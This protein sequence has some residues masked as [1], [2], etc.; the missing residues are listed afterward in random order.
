MTNDSNRLPSKHP[1]FE[2]SFRSSPAPGEGIILPP[3]G[4]ILNGL[5]ALPSTNIFELRVYVNMPN[6]SLH[7]HCYIIRKKRIALGQMGNENTRVFLRRR[8]VLIAQ[9][10]KDSKISLLGRCLFVDHLQPVIACKYKT[11]IWQ[12]APMGFILLVR[13]LDDFAFHFPHKKL[14]ILHI[15]SRQSRLCFIVSLRQG[16][17][18]L[19]LIQQVCPLVA[20]WF[21]VFWRLDPKNQQ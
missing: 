2:S 7:L 19:P 8:S 11:T 3:A 5:A 18:A 15:R 13:R 14:R 4:F 6:I 17:E 1:I 12:K 21:F 10:L 9:W 16:R 20:L